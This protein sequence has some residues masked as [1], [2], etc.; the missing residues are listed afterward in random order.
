MCMGMGL[1]IILR[2]LSDWNDICLIQL[3]EF[4]NAMIN[5]ELSIQNWNENQ[6]P[7]QSNE[8]MMGIFVFIMFG[9]KNS[10]K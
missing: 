8:V 5:Q 9:Y 4:E 1:P 3:S 10:L 7:Y 6:F 2:L